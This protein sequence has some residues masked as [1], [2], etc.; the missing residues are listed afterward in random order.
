VSGVGGIKLA[1]C[2]LVAASAAIAGETALDA[3]AYPQDTPKRALES[4]VKA[5][6]KRDLEY[7]IAH[8]ISPRD[9]ERLKEKHGGLQQAV[10]A[11][12]GAQ[13][14]ERIKAQCEVMR[15]ML[16]D[17]ELK[18]GEDAGVKWARFKSGQRV[19][20]LERQPDG[21]WCMNTRVA[22]EPAGKQN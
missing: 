2:A 11:N 4:L 13:H 8:L 22:G 19:L 10:E 6:E 5:L 21:R 20:Q 1:V 18:E 9:R 16:A 7:W 14:L 15:Q 3:T 17:G 12:S